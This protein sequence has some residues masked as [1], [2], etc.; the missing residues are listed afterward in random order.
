MF[1]GFELSEVFGSDAILK[2]DTER[3]KNVS[4]EGMIDI[5]DHREGVRFNYE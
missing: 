5:D 1:R 4:I 2:V 3:W